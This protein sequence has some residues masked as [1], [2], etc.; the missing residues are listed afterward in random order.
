MTNPAAL[1]LCLIED[2][3]IMGESLC[4]RFRL[5]GFTVDWHHNAAGAATSIGHEPYAVVISDVRLPDE[6]GDT[7]F[8]RLL[9]DVP[10]LPPFIFITGFGSIDRAVALL[11]LGAAD[12]VTKPFDLDQLVEK[13]NA[14]C[15]PRIAAPPGDREPTLGIS[16]AMRRIEQL[17]PRLA[18]HTRTILVTGESGVGKERVALELHRSDPDAATQPFV[19]VNCGALPESLIEAELFGYEKGAFTGATRTKKGVFEQA[20]GGTLFL[21]EI[22]EMPLPMQVKLLRAIQDRSIVRVGGEVP[23]P[24]EIRLVCATNRDLKSLVEQGDFREDLY[25]RINVI[26]LRVPPLRERREDVLWFAHKFLCECAGQYPEEEHTLDSAAERA[27]LSYDWPGNVRE[28]RHSIERACILSG[29]K[30]LGPEAF[31]GEGLDDDTAAETPASGLTEYLHVCERNHIR[32]TLET[33]HWHIGKTAAQ[34]GISRK[35]L[36]E[37]MKKLGIQGR[38]GGSEP[39]L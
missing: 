3:Q 39:A 12:Y 30:V 2:D 37:K 33:N 38:Q 21:D 18:R 13:I 11:K 19:A 28:L 26:D 22:G 16:S 20:H 34:L 8:T 31:F 15:Q 4:D 9:R 32:Q 1:K 6:S 29:Q 27:L 23:I 25:F 14:L 36:W 17:L 7:L 35:N 5:E 10:S 24:V